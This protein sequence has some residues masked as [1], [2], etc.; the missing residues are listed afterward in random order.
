MFCKFSEPS[1]DNV[2]NVLNTEDM[3]NKIKETIKT[4]GKFAQ[5]QKQNTNNKRTNKQTEEHTM[6]ENRRY[7][8]RI[9]YQLDVN[10][11]SSSLAQSSRTY[12]PL[13]KNKNKHWQNS[14]TNKQTMKQINKRTKKNR[15][16]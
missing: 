9:Q 4:K 8:Y 7:L 15:C 1:I 3:C 16:T 14:H 11:V 13:K 2:Y 12:L 10:G 5:K 6:K